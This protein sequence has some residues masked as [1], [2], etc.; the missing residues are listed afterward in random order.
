MA[1]K[2]RVAKSDA[3]DYFAVVALDFPGF[4]SVPVDASSDEEAL[5]RLQELASSGKIFEFQEADGSYDVQW[6]LAGNERVV[7]LWRSDGDA[8]LHEGPFEET[9]GSSDLGSAGAVA[10]LASELRLDS[11]ADIWYDA[12]QH[13]DEAAEAVID[14]LRANIESAADLIQDQNQLLSRLRD[15]LQPATSFG[16]IGAWEFSRHGGWREKGVELVTLATAMVGHGKQAA[17]SANSEQ[18]L[19]HGFESRMV[20]ARAHST[21]DLSDGPLFAGFQVTP[22]L[23]VRLESLRGVAAA[24]ALSQVHVVAYADWGPGDIDNQLRLQDPE[25]IVSGN[26]QL[27]FS[28]RPKH[29][30]Y[31]IETVPIDIADLLRRLTEIADEV[32]FLFD[33]LELKTM[34]LDDVADKKVAQQ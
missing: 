25:M 22:E 14:R 34:Y 29:S 24:N 1:K 18:E 32:V 7:A 8:P 21:S 13:G 2:K 3:T 11:A 19:M 12:R 6:D 4:R 31:L 15:H 5:T 9:S 28:D 33:E 23:L 30:D 20:V 17:P 16:G 27:W 10:S 26:G